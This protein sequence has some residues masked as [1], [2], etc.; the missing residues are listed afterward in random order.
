M[1]RID[2]VPTKEEVLIEEEKT[3]AVLLLRNAD[4]KQYGDLAARLKE[5]MALER[6]E[7]STTMGAMYGLMVTNLSQKRT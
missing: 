4:P 7:Y 2:D 6:D 5:G 1:D 3:K